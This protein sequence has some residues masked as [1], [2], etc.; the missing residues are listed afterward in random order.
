[1]KTIVGEQHFQVSARGFALTPSS[2]G[3]TLMY[4]ADGYEFTPWKEETPANEV[5]VVTG[6]VNGMYYY[7][8][9]NT[10]ELIL[11]YEAN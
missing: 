7:A 3:Y 1:M 11:T 10:D 6:A 9:G 2:S 4:S 5:L 8:K